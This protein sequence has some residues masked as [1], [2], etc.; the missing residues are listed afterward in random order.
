MLELGRDP[1]DLVQYYDGRERAVAGRS[2][3]VRLH[4]A[5]A[6]LDLDHDPIITRYLTSLIPGLARRQGQSLGRSDRWR[7]ASSP[8]RLA[9]P[10]RACPRRSHRS[11][12]GA[13][14]PTMTRRS[15]R[16]RYTC[17]CTARPAA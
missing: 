17:G 10:P 11:R 6:S 13:P 12:P 1:E 2:G 3:D 8:A 16:G 7:D 5:V 4:R 9:R 14:R 15:P